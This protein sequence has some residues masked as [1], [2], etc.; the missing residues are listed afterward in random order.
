[1]P[2]EERRSHTDGRHEETRAEHRVREPVATKLCR[3]TQKARQEPE[4][5]FGNLYQ[6]LR[7]D[8]LRECFTT[9]RGDAASGIDEVTKAEY[10]KELEPNLADLGDRLRAMG[11]R[12]QR[13][14]S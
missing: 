11:F 8:L 2:P 4:L 13:G 7:T 5:R 1:M 9:L 10:A 14:V 6:L 3:I 12:H